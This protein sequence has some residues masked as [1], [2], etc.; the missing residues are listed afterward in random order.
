M[1]LRFL[2]GWCLRSYFIGCGSKNTSKKHPPPH[3]PDDID[4]VGG[5][6]SL[7]A[8]TVLQL[9]EV[10]AHLIVLFQRRPIE[11]AAKQLELFQKA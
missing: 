4:S 11:L 10:N 3:K 1:K 6:R 8:Q 7:L 9:V 2:P 5:R